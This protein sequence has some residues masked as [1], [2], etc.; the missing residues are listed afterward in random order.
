LVLEG[1]VLLK[2]E[3]PNAGEIDN[4]AYLSQFALD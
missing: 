3:Q 1:F 2:S 4:S